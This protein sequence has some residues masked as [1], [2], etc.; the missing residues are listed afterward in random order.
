MGAPRDAVGAAEGVA[1][2][3]TDPYAAAVLLGAADA[4]RSAAAFAASP[5]EREVLTRTTA[6][7][8]AALGE[9]AFRAAYQT[10]GAVRLAEAMTR[11]GTKR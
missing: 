8:V 9:D 3:T 10:G 4:V 1:S 7:L 11:A 6:R 5:I 2:V